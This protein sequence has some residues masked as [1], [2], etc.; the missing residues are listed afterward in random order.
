[1]LF[2]ELTNWMFFSFRLNSWGFGDKY[3]KTTSG[4]G[5]GNTDRIHV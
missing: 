3:F 5:N 4:T 1:M 2:L